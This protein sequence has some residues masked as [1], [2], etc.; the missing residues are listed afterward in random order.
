MS[1][2]FSW[3]FD[4]LSFFGLYFKDAKLLFLGLDNAG[5]TTLLL[6]LKDDKIAAHTPTFH[7]NSEELIVGNVRFQTHDLGGHEAA[8]KLW[9][10]Y[11]TTVDG[12]V[13]L[14]DALDRERFPEAKK[15]L[16]A[17]LQDEMLQ[18]TPFLILGN[19]IDV[20]TAASEQELRNEL[21][22]HHTTG[23]DPSKLPEGTRP[24]EIFMCSVVRK[25]GYGEGFKWLAAFLR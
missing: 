17:L 16:D 3:V 22:L 15:E 10:D 6:M 14:V 18:T 2:W 19:K 1:G 7:P 8:R 4:A 9:R 11:F 5:K 20:P 24:I 21:G 25:M 23:K 12:I 13:F